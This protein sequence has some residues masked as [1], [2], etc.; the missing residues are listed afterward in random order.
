MILVPRTPTAE[1]L[2]DGWYG[3]HEEDATAVW[4]LMIEAWER[5]LAVGKDQEG[6]PFVGLAD[7]A[8]TD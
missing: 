7:S 6:A 8:D 2:K 3:A 4:R 1:M 5:R